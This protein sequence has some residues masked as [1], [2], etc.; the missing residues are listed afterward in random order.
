MASYW[1]LIE[2]LRNRKL[3]CWTL[4]VC[5]HC[6]LHFVA[7]GKFL[8]EI[9]VS[10]SEGLMPCCLVLEYC[11]SEQPAAPYSWQNAAVGQCVLSRLSVR[12]SLCCLER[13]DASAVLPYK[14]VSLLT[15]WLFLDCLRPL[16][17]EAPRP[18]ETS[19]TT[20]LPKRRHKPKDL[21]H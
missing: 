17:M 12:L 7:T 15:C 1:R 3:A 11:V 9:C 21:N 20:H 10:D 6:C 4:L 16:K 18:F 14:T 8:I 2:R 5:S 13:H 19:R